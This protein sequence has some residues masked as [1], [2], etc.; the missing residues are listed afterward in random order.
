MADTRDFLLEEIKHLLKEVHD[1]L[2][3][4]LKK[5][6]LK[7][8]V[9]SRRDDLS[10]Q[11]TSVIGKVDKILPT[12]QEEY[13]DVEIEQSHNAPPV[14]ED[15]ELY[16][17]TSIPDSP[18]KNIMSQGSNH[19]TP[20]EP[21]LPQASE[22]DENGEPYSDMKIGPIAVTDLNK[23]LKEGF[24]E[25]RR[26][27]G[28]IGISLWQ[29]RY[30]VIKENVFYYFKSSTDKQQKNVIVLNGY[31]ARPNSDFDKKHK[32]RDYIFEV[33]CPAKRS[34]QFI[35]SSSEEMKGWIDAIALASTVI[36]AVESSTKSI[37][38]A[39]ARTPTTEKPPSPIPEDFDETYDDVDTYQKTKM[40]KT[41][42]A[43]PPGDQGEL[44]DDTGLEI[45]D[46]DE[47][48]EDV[49][50][51]TK[52]PEGAP[53]PPPPR[54]GALPEVPHTPSQPSIQLPAIPTSQRPKPDLPRRV[55]DEK[56]APPRR[57]SEEKTPVKTESLPPP[58]TVPPP[59]IPTSPPKPEPWEEDYENIYMG[60]WDCFP[61]EDNELEFQR[62]DLVHIISKEFDSFNW[63]VGEKNS[64]IG[65]VPKAYLMMAYCL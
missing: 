8:D 5:E 45:I 1:F 53:R 6:K 56:P 26:K 51:G 27:E 4:T 65:L 60:M 40:Q 19:E 10:Q 11:I 43:P 46:T 22:K 54:H 55:S 23:P 21:E 13:A 48:Y 17:D 64:K 39:V 58:P 15:D 57:T 29:R 37:P 61:N 44:Y 31:E 24:L 41:P 38:E 34:Y 30:C 32:K 47:V 42:E 14:E 28:Q 16:E 20:E 25:K 33:V 3:I 9:G 49:S 12:E 2:S 36:P 59:P 63:W 50:S 52:E 7:K 18:N 62:G 35:A